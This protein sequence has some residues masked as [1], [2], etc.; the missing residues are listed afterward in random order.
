MTISGQHVYQ[1]LGRNIDFLEHSSFIAVFHGFSGMGKSRLASTIVG[2]YNYTR[3]A[4]GT[5]DYDPNPKIYKIRRQ[6]NKLMIIDV[7]GMGSR[8]PRD[9]ELI[10]WYDPMFKTVEI[11][12]NSTIPLKRIYLFVKPFNILKSMR[13]VF[14]M[15]RIYGVSVMKDVT[16]VLAKADTVVWSPEVYDAEIKEVRRIFKILTGFVPQVVT[17]SAVECLVQ[18]TQDFGKAIFDPNIRLQVRESPVIVETKNEIGEL[19]MNYTEKTRELEDVEQKIERRSYNPFSAIRYS[20]ARSSL[21]QRK[22][23]LV[24]E[25]ERLGEKIIWRERWLLEHLAK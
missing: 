12:K 20:V 8:L 1:D 23:E 17:V 2:D 14:A 18:M 10:T 7:P 6:S 15:K 3:A 21:I 19:R 11:I 13:Y 9:E 4:Y 22:E 24:P 16:I 5:E 25:I